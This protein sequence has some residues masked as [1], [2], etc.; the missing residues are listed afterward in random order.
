MRPEFVGHP[1]KAG[2]KVGASSLRR[3]ALLKL[4]A[5]GAHAAA[6]LRGNDAHAR[7]VKLV[8]GEYD[9]IVLAAAGASRLALD[10]GGLTVLR[11]EP[12]EVDSRSRPGCR[13]G[14]VSARRLRDTRGDRRAQARGD[15]AA[16]R[17]SSESSCAYSR[18]AARRP[19][20]RMSRGNSVWLGAEVGGKWRQRKLRLPAC[21]R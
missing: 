3:E 6:L 17:T 13:G 10:T 19:S 15:H 20:A 1:L 2:A 9:A 14:A 8:A 11:A 18:V 5:P 4:Y 12:Q 16:R 21:H 7:S